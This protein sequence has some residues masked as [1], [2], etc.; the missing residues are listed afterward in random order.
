MGTVLGA[1]TY[2]FDKTVTITAT[3]NNGYQFVRWSDD[4]TDNPR[5]LVVRQDTTLTAIFTDS[6]G[7]HKGH[8]YVD[9]GLPSGI[10]WATC[11]IGASK[12]EDSGD[13]FAWG[14]TEAKESYDWD[15]YEYGRYD[16]D[17]DYSKLTK[18]NPTDGKIVLD[19]SD[20]AATANWGGDW[21]MPTLEE[22]QELLNECTWTW[23]DDYNG[24]GVSG[25]MVMGSKGNSIFLPAAGYRYDS[26]LYAAK[27]FGFYWSSSL[28]LTSRYSACVLNVNPNDQIMGYSY[29]CS[30][31]SVRPVCSPR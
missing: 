20:D 6:D 22:Q 8:A 5:E 3:A 1:G 14:E 19:A 2:E 31:S 13:Y 26:N 24:K 9:L 11:N 30:G 23:T 10:L 27:A 28:Y 18:Y 12:P 17:S 25:Y 16:H 15:T 7:T 21:R 4:V 29:R